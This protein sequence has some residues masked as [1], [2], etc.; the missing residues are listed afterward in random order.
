[1]KRPRDRALFGLV[2]SL[3]DRTAIDKW[4]DLKKAGW[5]TASE[6]AKEWGISNPGAYIRCGRYL[7]EGTAD[8]WGG[9]SSNYPRLYN[10]RRE[11]PVIFDVR[12]E[13]T[14][15]CDQLAARYKIDRQGA[16]VWLNKLCCVPGFRKLGY[17]RGSQNL[18]GFYPIP[19]EDQL[20]QAGVKSR[21]AVLTKTSVPANL[22]QLITG[23]KGTE[24]VRNGLATRLG[25]PPIKLGS[26][27][28]ECPVFYHITPKG[29]SHI[30]KRLGSRWKGS[31]S[32]AKR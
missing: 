11:V 31:A 15:T 16:S 13:N 6:L 23:Q 19:T 21:N 12:P 7:R 4:I 10:I 18:V 17:I 26:E 20:S 27:Q 3:E 24:T 1:M 8:A 14:T 30:K 32:R 29:I 28:H 2:T 25:S 9:G 5:K 22:L